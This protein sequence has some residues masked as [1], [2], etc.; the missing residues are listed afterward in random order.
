MSFNWTSLMFWKKIPSKV[1]LA[2]TKAKLVGKR[3]SQD[4]V[5]GKLGAHQAQI[6]TEA[7]KYVTSDDRKVKELARRH[8]S[9]VKQASLIE[10]KRSLYDNLILAVESRAF[11]L[12]YN[13]DWDD[14]KNE[15]GNFGLH[16]MNFEKAITGAN[17]VMQEANETMLQLTAMLDQLDADDMEIGE[18]EEAFIHELMAEKEASVG[19]LESLERDVQR[20]KAEPFSVPS[21]SPGS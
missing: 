5:L 6:K 18:A 4:K 16:R 14:L 11:I 17:E 1:D 10:K 15:I 21:V 2:T 13:D 8:A 19:S 20:E 9:L 12:D 3:S 7:R